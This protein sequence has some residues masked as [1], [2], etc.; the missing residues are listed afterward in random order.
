MINAEWSNDYE[1]NKLGLQEVILN[2]IPKK[3]CGP[4]PIRFHSVYATQSNKSVKKIKIMVE[5]EIKFDSHL[6]Q[7]PE[8]IL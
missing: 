7:Y 2:Q 8:F 3:C 4:H 6:I 5:K 1:N